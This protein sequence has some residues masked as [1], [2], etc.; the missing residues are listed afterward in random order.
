M[1]D[2]QEMLERLEHLEQL[3]KKVQLVLLDWLVH[4]EILDHQDLQDQLG[5]SE[6]PVTLVLMGIE[7]QLVLL[8]LQDSR[9]C[10]YLINIQN[11]S[12]LGSIAVMVI[13]CCF[14]PLLES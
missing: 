10:D 13:I 4:L 7:D 1:L 3:V 14:S 12:V 2:Q 9:V 8:D 11:I 6:L 5:P